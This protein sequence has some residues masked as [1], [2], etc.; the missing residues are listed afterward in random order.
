MDNE[1]RL[2][3]TNLQFALRNM[4]FVFEKLHEVQNAASKAMLA[5][6]EEMLKDKF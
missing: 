1:K 5:L 6:Q 2:E 3:E 4:H